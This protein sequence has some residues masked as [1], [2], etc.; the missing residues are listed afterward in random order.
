MITDSF[1]PEPHD[2]VD[3]LASRLIDGDVRAAEI[4]D[5]LRAEVERR[6][7]EFS[8]LR[9]LVRESPTPNEN[10]ILRRAQIA[11][12]LRRSS[13]VRTMDVVR[14]PTSRVVFVAAASIIGVLVVATVVLRGADSDDVDVFAESVSD[15]SDESEALA[16]MAPAFDSYGG[17]SKAS[18]S[19]TEDPTIAMA[20]TDE[21]DR[22][23]PEYSSVDEI[24]RIA[25]SLPPGGMPSEGLNTRVDVARCAVGPTQP[26]RTEE[27]LLE[28]ARVEIHFREGGEFAVYDMST[29]SMLTSRPAAP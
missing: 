19:E 2:D 26:L 20:T 1:S 7:A 4:P 6:A 24:A 10:P 9:A 23:L 18:P 16:H 8:N 3:L 22:P 15:A 11:R 27:A 13:T 29:C 28:G 14:Q 5:A 25:A 21:E 12:A 17:R